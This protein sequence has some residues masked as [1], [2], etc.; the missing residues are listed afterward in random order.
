M[1]SG[2]GCPASGWTSEKVVAVNV[3]NGGRALFQ[4]NATTLTSITEISSTLFV[5]VNP[6]KPPSESTLQTAVF[7][8]NQNRKP[9]ASF[10]ANVSGTQILLNGSDSEDPEEKALDYYWYDPAATG[11]NCGALPSGVPQTGC[12][13]TGILMTYSPS[14][15]GL[16]TV[17]L[18][19]R[20]PAG[21][22]AQ[23][24]NWTG[25]TGTGC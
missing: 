7:L 9:V 4:Y 10:T 18:V 3:T 16:H 1:P 8:R 23:A 19:V 6:N 24:P 17:Y 2:T 22:T 13:G 14:T 20:D 25:C 12:I 21:L 15:T 5:D 11:N